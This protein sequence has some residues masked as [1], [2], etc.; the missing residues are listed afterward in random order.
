V[1]A[2]GRTARDERRRDLGQTFLNAATADRLVEQVALRRG[3]LVVEIGAGSGAITLALARR[4]ARV[5]AIEADPAWC[6]RLRERLGANRQ[7]RVVNGDFMTV[8]LPA[9]PF[10]VFGSLPFGR[11]TDILRRLLDDPS[12]ALH[13]A[14]LIVQWEV[15]R[16]RATVPPATLLSTL[17]APWWELHTGPRIPAAEFRP[18]PRVDAALL[19]ISRRDPPVLPV[20]MAQPY[21]DFVRQTW[22]FGR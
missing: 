3:E 15:A 12:I 2:R 14:D 13:R 7:V 18:V 9:A 10:R 19:T 22:P 20:S 11:T 21:A 5:V 6:D 8:P 4:G 1:S 17:W 16:K